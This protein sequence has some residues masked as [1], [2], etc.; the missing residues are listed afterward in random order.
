MI[1]IHRVYGTTLP[2]DRQRIQQ[3]QDIFRQNFA[4]VPSYADKIPDLLA[5]PFKYGYT[6]ILLVCE[7]AMAKVTGFSLI[8]HFPEI[9]SSLLDFIAAHRQM[10]GGGIGG[11]LFE[12]T[13]EYVQSQGSRG[14]Y[15]EAPPDDPCQ[16]KDPAQ[17][18]ENQRRLRFYEYYGL[19]PIVNTEYETPIG[20]SPAPYLLFDDLGQGAPLRRS[21]ARVAIRLILNRKYS[22]LLTADYIERV[23]ESVIDDPVRFREPRYIKT[24]PPVPCR[25]QVEKA[26]EIVCGDIHVVHRVRDRGYVERPARVTVLEQAAMATGLF[27]RVQPRHYGDE[28]L[29]AVHDADFL[30]YLKAACEK[31]PEGTRIYPYVFPIRRPDRRP[32]DLAVRA[33]YYCIDTFTPLDHQ[34]YQAARQAVDVALTAAEDVLRGRR[35]A[36]ALCRPP[37]HHAERRT[38]GG[39]CY[40]NNAAIAAQ[41]LTHCGTAAML[42]IDYHHGN[43]GQD[44]FYSRSDVLTVSLHG[45]PN[46]SY[47]YFSGFADELG[48]GPGKGFNHNFPLPE[49][50]DETLYLQTLDKA[51]RAIERFKPMFLIV[52]VGFDTIRGDP[53][54][55]FVLKPSSLRQVGQRIGQLQLP[56]LVVQEGG[57]S[58]RNL[59]QGVSAFFGGIAQASAFAFTGVKKWTKQQERSTRNPPDRVTP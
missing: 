3:T 42:D 1:W 48:E 47:P 32:K 24:P 37:G 53:T 23:V 59:R 17:L 43:G 5:H 39:F 36:Y 38:F 2:I 34:A 55:S 29:R 19:R 9:N 18:K 35:V 4:A 12:A 14:L 11:S 20:P 10:R 6:T 56:T 21:E 31:L 27:T 58:L 40:F 30:S 28:H 26:F 8:L 22:H 44:I 45:H 46:H 49:G 54:G 15:I 16:V 52:C 41:F 7:T 33:G 25:E 57:Y 51:I 13:E 50:T